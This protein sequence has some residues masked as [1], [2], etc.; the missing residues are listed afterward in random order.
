[1][2]V[3]ASSASLGRMERQT[4]LPRR[5]CAPVLLAVI[6]AVFGRILALSP[7]QAN[8]R[9]WLP[10]LSPTRPGGDTRNDGGGCTFDKTTNQHVPRRSQ[11]LF[12]Q[13]TQFG[14]V[15]DFVGDPTVSFFP[16]QD[17]HRQVPVLGNAGLFL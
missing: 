1:M 5:T 16:R 14:S 7:G 6:A 10:H 15:A 9:G 8:V 11:R 3:I 2:P 12:V 17:D 4:R 13:T